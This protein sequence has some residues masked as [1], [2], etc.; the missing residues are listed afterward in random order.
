[1]VAQSDR[2]G[3]RL[4]SG[5]S[6][7]IAGRGGQPERILGPVLD[8]QYAGGIAVRPTA[9]GAAEADQRDADDQSGRPFESLS[10]GPAT[11]GQLDA[12]R[13]DASSGSG[14]AAADLVLHG[15]L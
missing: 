7:A 12:D 1:M 2:E 5:A 4:R 10:R 6:Q 15:E 14:R 11:E 13:L 3:L 9:A 8:R